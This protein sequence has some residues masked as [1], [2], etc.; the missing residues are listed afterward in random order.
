MKSVK[1]LPLPGIEKCKNPHL[2]GIEKCINIYLASET[3]LF[4]KTGRLLLS[5][6]HLF[7]IVKYATVRFYFRNLAMTSSANSFQSATEGY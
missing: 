1:K 6:N 4:T 7:G 3:L 5:L 2:F